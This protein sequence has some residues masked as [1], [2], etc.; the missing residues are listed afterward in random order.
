M[1]KPKPRDLPDLGDLARPGT[2]ITLR[3]TPGA[4]RTALIRDGDNLRATVTAPPE[5]GRANDA[6][7]TMLATAMGVAPSHLTLKQG[8]TARTK[9]FVYTGP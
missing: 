5:N 6:V 4:R 9:T 2:V 1:A 3:V 8:Q 7:R